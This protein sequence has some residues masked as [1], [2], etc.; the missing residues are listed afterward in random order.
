ESA[1]VSNRHAARD[2]DFIELGLHDYPNAL[3]RVT[4]A[5]CGARGHP[6]ARRWSADE[7]SAAIDRNRSS[8]DPVASTAS[9]KI[10]STPRASKP[11]NQTVDARGKVLQR[12]RSGASTPTWSD[13]SEACEGQQ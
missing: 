9:F 3:S 2:A 11:L 4:G 6:R 12:N 13:A 10:A 7:H 8:S 1:Q 5:A